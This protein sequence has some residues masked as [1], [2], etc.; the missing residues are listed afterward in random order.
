M[1]YGNFWRKI[2]CCCSNFGDRMLPGTKRRKPVMY[3][4]NGS[5]LY[6]RSKGRYVR[7]EWVSVSQ[8]SFPYACT[9]PLAEHP[10]L[11][12]VSSSTP[13]RLSH[14]F[15]RSRMM[16][17]AC[18]LLFTKIYIP[19][20]YLIGRHAVVWITIWESWESLHYGKTTEDKIAD[21]RGFPNYPW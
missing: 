14:L 15:S 6:T 3:C 8:S 17:F 12:S 1:S 21:L 19:Q 5:E 20:S 7:L 2:D 9:L 4:L 16:V 18:F 10:V 13:A 11:Y